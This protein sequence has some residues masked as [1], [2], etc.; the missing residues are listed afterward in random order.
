MD[1]HHEVEAIFNAHHQVLSVVD[2]E[3]EL[4]LQS[5]V[6]VDT[7]LY[8]NFVIFR[9]PISFISYWNSLPSIWI[10]ISK[11]LSYASN[12][13]FG[14]NVRLLIQMVMVSIRIV[15]PSSGDMIAHNAHW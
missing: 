6:N 14:E 4:S 7:S 3:V 8:A 9:I 1:T 15:E 12:D 13:S 11:S 2:V 5:F 10:H